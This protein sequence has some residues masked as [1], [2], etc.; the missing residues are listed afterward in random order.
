MEAALRTEQG[1]HMR[2]KRET[3]WE[4][5]DSDRWFRSLLG[6]DWS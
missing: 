1:D 6:A 5:S 3:R 2:K 4:T